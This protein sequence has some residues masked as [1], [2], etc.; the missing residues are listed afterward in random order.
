MLKW[1]KPSAEVHP[2]IVLVDV[3]G[4]PPTIVYHFVVTWRVSSFF[5]PQFVFRRWYSLRIRFTRRRKAI[6]KV[7]SKLERRCSRMSFW[8]RPSLRL[9]V[10]CTLHSVASPIDPLCWR[11]SK[12]EKG[13]VWSHLALVCL[14]PLHELLPFKPPCLHRFLPFSYRRFTVS[15]ALSSSSEQFRS[16][17]ILDPSMSSP[18]CLLIFLSE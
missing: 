6:N 1:I 17:N 13:F 18:S 5:S 14:V 12:Q 16:A 10:H 15:P 7:P 11:I 3:N 4:P 8:S 9:S 2:F